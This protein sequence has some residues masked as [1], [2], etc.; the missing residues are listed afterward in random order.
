MKRKIYAAGVILSGVLLCACGANKESETMAF[1]TA[2]AAETE[3]AEETEETEEKE[4]EYVH[5]D[6]AE[7]FDTFF[8]FEDYLK[9]QGYY[10]S[11]IAPEI[12]G[13]NKELYFVYAEP[14]EDG[15]AFGFKEDMKTVTFPEWGIERITVNS[16]LFPDDASDVITLDE[17]KIIKRQLTDDELQ[18]VGLEPGTVL[19]VP[20]YSEKIFFSDFGYAP[21]ANA[22]VDLSPLYPGSFTRCS[23]KDFFQLFVRK[24]D[25]ELSPD[26]LGDITGAELLEKLYPYGT[27]DLT[28][29][30]YNIYH[31]DDVYYVWMTMDDDP[32]KQVVHDTKEEIYGRTGTVLMRIADGICEGIMYRSN[33]APAVLESQYAVGRS[34]IYYGMDKITEGLCEDY[35][36]R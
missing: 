23:P 14:D 34:L 4:T 11:D 26:T 18:K 25:V 31:K 8:A 10:T 35:R 17:S 32:E 9:Y 7:T 13:R 20:D 21:N 36:G 3:A 29:G 12:G 24:T 30:E 5:Y 6:D 27:Y 19:E 28:V 15:K 2:T 16:G 22:C 33:I 1:E